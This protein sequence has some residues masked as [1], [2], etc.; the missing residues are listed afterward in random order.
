MN[1]PDYFKCVEIKALLVQMGVEN[2]TP[3]EPIDF[4]RE[5]KTVKTVE[6]PNNQ[7]QFAE[8]LNMTAV[9]LDQT[10]VS[11]AKDGTIEVNGMKAC[12]YIKKQRKGIDLSKKES[13]YRYHL[14]NCQT[15]QSMIAS[16]RKS[17]YVSTTRSD[18]LFPVIDQSGYRAKE[19]VLKLELCMNCKAILESKNMLPRPFSLK[20]FFTKYQPDIPKTILRTEQVITQEQYAPNHQEIAERYKQQANYACQL[21]G[22]SCKEERPCLHLH[23]K[24]G[25]GQ[26]NNASNLLVLCADCHSKQPMHSQMQTNPQFASQFQTIERL[27]KEQSILQLHR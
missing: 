13:K 4:V 27:R 12:A 25:E 18:G 7:I 1:L 6:V 24:D 9:P 21:C 20:T 26:N 15:I 14:C 19:R 11:I 5:V 22:V 3:L 2:V 17:R 16:G 10:N 23:H 8:R